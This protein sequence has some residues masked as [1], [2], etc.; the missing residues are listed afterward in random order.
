MAAYVTSSNLFLLTSITCPETDNLNCIY[1]DSISI[2]RKNPFKNRNNG[3][4]HELLDA[5]ESLD[6]NHHTSFNAK[7][8]SFIQK[9]Y[10]FPH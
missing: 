6:L 4:I 3:D 5:Q 1:P 2:C 9:S 10:T 8:V 7:L